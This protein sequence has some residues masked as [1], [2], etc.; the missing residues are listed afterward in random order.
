MFWTDELLVCG[1][2]VWHAATQVHLIVQLGDQAHA[3]GCCRRVIWSTSAACEASRTP[4]AYDGKTVL[5][6]QITT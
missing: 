6:L 3:D 2:H 1:S 5:D 4:P